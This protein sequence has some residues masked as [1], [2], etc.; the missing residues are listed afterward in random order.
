MTYTK[1]KNISLALS[2]CFGGI[3]LHRFYQGEIAK[4]IFY[5]AFS[6]TL[7][8]LCISV[9]DIIK[10]LTMDKKSYNKKYNA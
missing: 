2:I 9:I 5:L 3:G 1:D 7:I 6:W 4:G 10:L 8:P